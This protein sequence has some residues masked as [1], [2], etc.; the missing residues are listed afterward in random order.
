LPY[1][2]FAFA[3]SGM[4]MR[5][6]SKWFAMSGGKVRG[7]RRTTNLL[8]IGVSICTLLVIVGDSISDKRFDGFVEYVA[9]ETAID[10]ETSIKACPIV[11]L[12]ASA[13]AG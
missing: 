6:F 3:I 1:R 8:P 2:D 10:V 9:L 13:W 5:P 11:E 12:L 7:S 4:T